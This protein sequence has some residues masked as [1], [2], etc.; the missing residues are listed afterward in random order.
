MSDGAVELGDAIPISVL[1]AGEGPER[2]SGRLPAVVSSFGSDV[3]AFGC[4][5]ADASLFAS[6]S[7]MAVSGDSSSAW[8]LR[9][10]GISACDLENSTQN[11]FCSSILRSSW[12]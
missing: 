8:S 5:G 3:D 12:P 2:L 6:W 9:A 10:I 7:L 1:L 4:P 11:L